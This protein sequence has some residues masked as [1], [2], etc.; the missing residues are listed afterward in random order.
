M[1]QSG[2]PLAG[3]EERHRWR[4]AA[5]LSGLAGQAPG[6]GPNPRQQPVSDLSVRGSVG[7]LIGLPPVANVV[8]RRGSGSLP[9][10]HGSAEFSGS[11]NMGSQ[12]Y[13]SPIHQ[14]CWQQIAG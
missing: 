7:Q 11:A 14:P 9:V 4:L 12:V 3:R 6:I 10:A 1:A 8:G 2:E 5:T 13:N